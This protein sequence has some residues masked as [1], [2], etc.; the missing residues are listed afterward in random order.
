MRRRR[1]HSGEYYR[2]MRRLKKRRSDKTMRYLVLGGALLAALVVIVGRVFLGVCRGYFYMQ[3]VNHF[4][5]TLD[6]QTPAGVKTNLEHFALGLS[7]DNLLVRDGSIVA[8]K[9]ATGWNL[10]KD[11]ADWRQ[12]WDDHKEHWTYHLSGSTNA[13]PAAATTGATVNP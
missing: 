10:G 3:D 8:M 4:T 13:P 6:Q 9:A 5:A 2:E 1:Y 11:A 12:W 7:D